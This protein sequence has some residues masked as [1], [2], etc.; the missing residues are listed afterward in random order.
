MQNVS[1]YETIFLFAVFRILNPTDKRKL[2]R[3]G[4][5]C[6]FDY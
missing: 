1:F 6:I 5:P 3:M 4:E 2:N